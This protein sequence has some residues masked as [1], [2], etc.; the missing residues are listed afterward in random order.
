M[1]DGAPERLR[2]RYRESLSELGQ[3]VVG[4]ALGRWWGFMAGTVGG[5]G[6]LCP[7]DSRVL[8]RRGRFM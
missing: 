6:V 5:V 2:Q 3:L 1:L 4:V 8:R 7:A